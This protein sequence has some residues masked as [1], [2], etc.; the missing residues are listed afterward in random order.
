MMYDLY[1]MTC[2]ILT[3]VCF[4]YGNVYWERESAVVGEGRS[5]EL[6][7]LHRRARRP[8]APKAYAGGVATAAAIYAASWETAASLE[9]LPPLVSAAGLETAA[10]VEDPELAEAEAWLRE[11]DLIRPGEW[12][13]GKQTIRRYKAL[14]KC[15]FGEGVTM[16]AKRGFLTNLIHCENNL[17]A[18]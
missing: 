12:L 16:V 13:S 8:P 6:P 14:S 10:S 15:Q 11:H 4:C 9:D 18:Q 3:L 2:T 1:Y 17:A 7:M 5:I